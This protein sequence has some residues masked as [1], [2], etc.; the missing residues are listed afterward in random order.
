MESVLIIESDQTQLERLAFGLEKG[1][2][3]VKRAEC[4]ISGLELCRNYTPDAIVCQV[5]LPGLGVRDLLDMRREEGSLS[6]VPVLVISE[7]SVDKIDSFRAGCEDYLQLPSDEGELLFRLKALIKR[8]R[9]KGVS[10]SFRDISIFDLIQLFMGARQ[11]GEL[12]VDCGELS[13]KLI[14]NLG[15]VIFAECVNVESLEAGEAAFVSLL[16]GAEK[17]GRFVFEKAKTDE[18]PRNIEKRTD[19]LLLGIANILDESA[20]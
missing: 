9:N 13:G 11:S 14:L 3:S 19:H 6:A 16:K 7:S 8:A 5:N 10:G 1:G 17:G 12:V 4:V 18:A 20:S 2:F 15:Q